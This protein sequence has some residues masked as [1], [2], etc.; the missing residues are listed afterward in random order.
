MNAVEI[1]TGGI[2]RPAWEARLA[3]FCRKALRRMGTDGWEV[4]VLLCDDAIMRSLNRKYG[5]K[6]S[7]TDVLSFRQADVVGPGRPEVAGDIVI[8]LDT[9][10]RN[11]ESRGIS[12]N[13]ELKRLAVH[14]LLHLAGM[15]HGRGKGGG[16]LALQERLLE[17]LARERIITK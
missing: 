10:R 14:G 9:L 5:G 4:S 6:D 15:D 17:E 2:S 3:R 12:E 16:M 7:T 11:A 13:E 8:S 1:S